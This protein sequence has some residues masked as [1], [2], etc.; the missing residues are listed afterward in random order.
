MLTIPASKT[1]SSLCLHV[2]NQMSKPA[3]VWT[4]LNIDCS[5][6]VSY[7]WI[8]HLLKLKRKKSIEHASNITL[9]AKHDLVFCQCTLA[10]LFLL[11]K[12][13][14]LFCQTTHK[15]LLICSKENIQSFLFK[16]PDIIMISKKN[17][18]C[19]SLKC[20]TDN[21]K[22]SINARWS[23]IKYRRY[24]DQLQLLERVATERP[25]STS[26]KKQV[27]IETKMRILSSSSFFD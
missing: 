13:L 4:E 17:L 18:C 25:E 1:Q 16:N 7:L 23:Y 15:E 12:V 10:P 14:Q 5:L 8:S 24:T 19:C 21:S 11:V 20:L 27:K 9:R 26:K 3:A 22:L 6:S 2:A